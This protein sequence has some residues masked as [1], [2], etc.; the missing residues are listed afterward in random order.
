ME[1]FRDIDRRIIYADRLACAL[2][3]RAVFRAKRAYRVERGFCK[4][5]TVH[6]KIKVAVDRRNRRYD[7]VRNIRIF[8]FFRYNR[9][10]FTHDFREFE[11]RQ[12]VIAHG[13][14]RRNDNVRRYFVC[15]EFAYGKSFRDIFSVIHIKPAMQRR[16]N[17]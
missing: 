3:G 13:F 8:K 15:R 6:L 10:G 4:P 12:R 16:C 1:G 2:V 9:G 17:V 11:T 14:I 5:D 7:V